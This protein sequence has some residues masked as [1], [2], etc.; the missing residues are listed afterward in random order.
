MHI[1]AGEAATVQ[2]D[3]DAG[4]ALTLEV[5]QN[6]GR[7]RRPSGDDPDQLQFYPFGVGP[8][9]PAQAVALAPIP[10]PTVINGDHAGSTA[11]VTAAADVASWSSPAPGP[12]A[13]CRR[14]RPG[15]LQ[16]HRQNPGRLSRKLKDFLR[17]IHNLETDADGWTRK[18]DKG[19]TGWAAEFGITDRAVRKRRQALLSAGLIEV[20]RRPRWAAMRLTP[21]GKAILNEY[22]GERNKTQKFRSRSP[23]SSGQGSA[24]IP[25]GSGE[26]SAA[27]T[28]PEVPKIT[29]CTKRAGAEKNIKSSAQTAQS[30]GKS[31][32]LTSWEKSPLFVG[33]ITGAATWPEILERAKFRYMGPFYKMFLVPL[34]AIDAG[35]DG[36]VLIAPDARIAKHAR[37]RYL[38]ELRELGHEVS[39]ERETAKQ[40][41]QNDVPGG[42]D[43]Q[44]GPP[45]DS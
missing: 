23:K 43:R 38:A 13:A 11:A 26:G 22:L 6:D 37:H 30:A 1:A 18:P 12:G 4:G 2:V 27:C 19:P 41:N 40:G 8:A 45:A 29:H 31:S 28:L 32:A 10:D 34:R 25:K 36:F 5:I 33:S 16:S 20:E 35:S 39:N 9:I 3:V 24:G 42:T 17:Q 14:R 7:R 15:A 21:A 44:A